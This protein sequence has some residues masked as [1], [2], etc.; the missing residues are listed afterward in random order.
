MVYFATNEMTDFDTHGLMTMASSPI[1]FDNALMSRAM[2]YNE[3]SDTL[4]DKMLD[5]DTNILWCHFVTHYQS[6]SSNGIWGYDND[7][8]RIFDLD[9]NRVAGIYRG[10]STSNSFQTRAQSATIVAS[11][12][13]GVPAIRTVWDVCVDMTGSNIVVTTYLNG[14]LTHTVSVAKG[15]RKNIKRVEWRPGGLRF[16]W[17][18]LCMSEFILSPTSTLGQQVATLLPNTDG[19]LTEMAGNVTDLGTSGDGLGLETNAPN[20]RHTWN[21]TAYGGPSKPIAAVQVSLAAERSGGS[22]SVI[23]PFFRKAGLN[24]D[25]LNIAV[26]AYTKGRQVWTV[27]P[28]TGLPW[29]VSDLTGLEIGLKSGG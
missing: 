24:Y 8:L 20:Q 1:Q 19:G 7:W 18:N 3:G 14:G 4:F 15:T 6:D 27:N 29:T 2:F 25:G 11:G 5:G 12:A 28:I 23:A 17:T 10:G 13:L 9:G 26:G 21:P 16:N 22:P